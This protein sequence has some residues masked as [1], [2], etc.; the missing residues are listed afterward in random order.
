M[1]SRHRPVKDRH[2]PRPKPGLC[3]PGR[4]KYLGTTVRLGKLG[5]VQVLATAVPKRRPGRGKARANEGDFLVRLLSGATV[6][7]TR[8]RVRD[9]VRTRNAPCPLFIPMTRVEA[10]GYP[11]YREREALLERVHPA[12]GLDLPFPHR[13]GSGPGCLSHPSHPDHVE[14]AYQS[15]ASDEWV[16]SLAR[17]MIPRELAHA[18]ALDTPRDIPA[19]IEAVRNHNWDVW[20][21]HA[22]AAA[23]RS[24]RDSASRERARLRDEFERK[25]TLHE[26]DMSDLGSFRA[27]LAENDA[28]GRS[29]RR[30]GGFRTERRR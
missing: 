1:A 13:T 28:D 27:A 19:A 22:H 9:A 24:P 12:A 8:S 14:A 6:L 4:S 26:V 29:R 16:M 30:T 17:R 7:V 20:R 11:S 3:V 23:G 25:G 18:V 15:G 2:V 5:L 10:V 21:R